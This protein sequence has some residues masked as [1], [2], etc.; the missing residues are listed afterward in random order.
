MWDK[1]PLTTLLRM[2]EPLVFSADRE[3]RK[4]ESGSLQGSSLDRG[5]IVSTLPKR[6]MRKAFRFHCRANQL[7]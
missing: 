6:S 3:H 1:T 5:T 4:I 2:A 7:K